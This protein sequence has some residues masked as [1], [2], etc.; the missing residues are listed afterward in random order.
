MSTSSE[1]S[2]PLSI[3]DDKPSKLRIRHRQDRT[4]WR[5][6]SMNKVQYVGP[7]QEDI[8]AR[9][10]SSCKGTQRKITKC[11]KT[12]RTIILKKRK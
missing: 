8:I 5:V 12:K 4:E 3:F 2:D 1:D 11:T 6:S 7:D 10:V 9:K